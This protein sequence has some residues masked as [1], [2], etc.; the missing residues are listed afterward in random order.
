MELLFHVHILSATDPQVDC[1]SGIDP[2]VGH[3][4]DVEGSFDI[5]V[6]GKIQ[7]LCASMVNG[8]F[9]TFVVAV[10]CLK[11]F[12]LCNGTVSCIVI[13]EPRL[14]VICSNLATRVVVEE[15]VRVVSQSGL[16]IFKSTHFDEDRVVREDAKRTDSVVL[17]Y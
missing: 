11:N 16:N 14:K 2:G 8:D 3:C 13:C 10:F 5:L 6:S 1:L 7:G 12:I 9:L 4:S 17:G 15:V